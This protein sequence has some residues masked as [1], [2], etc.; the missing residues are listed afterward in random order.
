VLRVG[1]RRVRPAGVTHR[2][3]AAPQI[4]LE[5]VH[6]GTLTEVLGPT[7]PFPETC[8]AFACKEVSC[9]FTLPPRSHRYARVQRSGSLLVQLLRGLAFMHRNHRLHRD[10]KSDNILVGFNGDVK[11]ADFGFATSLTV[12]VCHDSPEYSVCSLT[13]SLASSP[14]FALCGSK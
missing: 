10:I 12:E 7:I 8:I 4:V 5:F 2:C 9:N 1:R 6:G 13:P 11:I 3:V 14:S